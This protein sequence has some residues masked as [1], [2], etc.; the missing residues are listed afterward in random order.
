MRAADVMDLF[1]YLF[2]LRDQVLAA[3]AELPADAFVSRTAVL[4][5]LDPTDYPTVDALAAHWR[6]DEAETRRRLAGLT[7]E[8]LAATAPSKG[9]LATRCRHA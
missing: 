4:M 1:G 6:R 3:T 2:R 9:G 7:D 8:E 5:E